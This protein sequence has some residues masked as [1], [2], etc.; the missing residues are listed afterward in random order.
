MPS[1]EV[2]RKRLTDGLNVKAADVAKLSGMSPAAFYK[3]IERGEVEAVKIGRTRLIPP[4][5]GRRILGMKPDAI[6]A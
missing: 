5:E 2:I 6:A 4:H 3:A 1:I